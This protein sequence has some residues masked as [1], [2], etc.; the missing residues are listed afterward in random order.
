MTS[1]FKY[2]TVL[3]IDFVKKKKMQEKI[4][5]THGN[6]TYWCIC[7]QKKKLQKKFNSKSEITIK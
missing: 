3:K 7:W 4:R 1:K 6:F 5:Y 2:I